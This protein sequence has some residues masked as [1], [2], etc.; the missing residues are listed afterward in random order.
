VVFGVSY[1]LQQM[2]KESTVML[3]GVVC[4]GLFVWLWEFVVQYFSGCVLSL[5]IYLGCFPLSVRLWG[6]GIFVHYCMVLAG[7]GSECT[8]KAG[9]GSTWGFQLSRGIQGS[10]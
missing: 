10:I 5:V 1:R 3:L 7:C 2:K 4:L 6:E 9:V 8:L